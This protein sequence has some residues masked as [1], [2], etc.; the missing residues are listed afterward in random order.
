MRRVLCAITDCNRMAHWMVTYQGVGIEPAKLTA[1][2]EHLLEHQERRKLD[3]RLRGF[4][5]RPMTKE[6]AWEQDSHQELFA[7]L[8]GVVNL[9]HED[10]DEGR[11]SADEACERARAHCEQFLEDLR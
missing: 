11:I 4:G 3:G 6:E 7:G 9:L 5:Y 2:N 1:C 8:W 10:L